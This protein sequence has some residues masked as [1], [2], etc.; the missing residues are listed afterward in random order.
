[1]GT[2]VT[3]AAEGF[4]RRSFTVGAGWRS[5]VERLPDE[6]LTLAALPGFS[7]PLEAV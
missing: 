5:I 4:D 2:N 3:R 1:M 7:I 6:A